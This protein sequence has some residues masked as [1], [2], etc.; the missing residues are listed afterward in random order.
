MAGREIHFRIFG[1]VELI[2]LSFYN[3][4]L[5]EVELLSLKQKIM[6]KRIARKYRYYRYFRIRDNLSTQNSV[7]L[8]K[9]CNHLVSKF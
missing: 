5:L 9:C 4:S 2:K 8:I 1:L 6:L 7:T 3:D